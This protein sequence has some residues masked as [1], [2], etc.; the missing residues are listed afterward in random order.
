M[1]RLICAA[2]VLGVL[3]CPAPAAPQEQDPLDLARVR[4]GSFG[5]T[6]AVMVSGGYDSNVTREPG[7]LGDYEFVTLPFL[8]TWLHL[9]RFV[10]NTQSAFEVFGYPHELPT[11]TFNNHNGVSL[12]VEGSRVE[13]KLQYVHRNT[14]A[15][16]TGFEI[17][18]RSRRLVDEVTADVKW[19]AGSKTTVLAEGRSTRTNWDGREPGLDAARDPERNQQHGNGRRVLRDDASDQLHGHLQGH[20]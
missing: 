13:P 9:G 15:R 12:T 1:V 19:F 10:F 20:R 8:E 5:F 4:L 2:V 6:P 16:P 18:S 17:N 14:Y 11:W 3:A 7:A